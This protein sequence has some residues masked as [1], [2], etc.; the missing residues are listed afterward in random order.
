MNDK[1]SY[2]L[3]KFCSVQHNL[4]SIY[5]SI[6]STY[7]ESSKQMGEGIIITTVIEVGR[8]EAEVLVED[9]DEAGAQERRN[10]SLVKVR[11][12]KN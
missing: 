4:F 11:E 3:V 2:S 7:V 5:I 9:V 8:L 12:V 10:R 1:N 6:I